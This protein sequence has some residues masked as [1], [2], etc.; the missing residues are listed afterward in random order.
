MDPL[1]ALGIQGAYI[2][3]TIMLV[4]LLSAS[5][6]CFHAGPERKSLGKGSLAFEG[7]LPPPY[8]VA[9]PSPPVDR[10]VQTAEVR[11]MLEAKSYRRQQRG[12]AP[13]DVEAEMTHLLDSPESSSPD[14][15]GMLRA[16]IRELVV[17]RNERRV[18]RG[19]EPLD[20]EAETERQI[21]DFTGLAK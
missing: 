6:D 5:A 2:V 12:E 20:V 13:L 14:L 21:A 7:R 9:M 15:E 11:Q 4:G 17:S 1:G 16:E 3:V 19:K 18:R 8:L 10:V